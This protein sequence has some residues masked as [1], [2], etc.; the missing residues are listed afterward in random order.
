MRWKEQEH[1][2]LQPILQSRDHQI[3]IDLGPNSIVYKGTHK[4]HTPDGP[5]WWRVFVSVTAAIAT[6]ALFGYLVLSLFTGQ[7]PF[8]DS[9]NTVDQPVQATAPSLNG[10]AA[11]TQTNGSATSNSKPSAKLPGTASPS[12]ENDIA[13]VPSNVYYLLQYGVF[14]TKDSMNAAMSELKAK[15]FPAVS[16]EDG[17]Y[18]VYA[19]A[20]TTKE[21]ADGLARELLGLDVYSKRVESGA[22]AAAATDGK[23]GSSASTAVLSFLKKSSD[24]S[25]LLLKLSVANLTAD[26]ARALEQQD[27]DRLAG[28]SHD[29]LNGAEAANS[30]SESSLVNANSIVTQLKTALSA[31]QSYKDK[32]ARSSLWSVQSSVMKALLAERTLLDQL[33]SANQG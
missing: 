1:R 32:P 18:R 15:G 7:S 12:I 26:K 8:P 4:S 27:A 29:W 21:E 30:L 28:L 23:A 19:G 24:L 20:A 9:A 31:I 3:D 14:T 11:S 16:Q 6:G 22:L 13:G 5:S 17:G 2:E 25:D 33:L 10:S